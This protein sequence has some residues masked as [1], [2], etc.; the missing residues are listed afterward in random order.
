MIMQSYLLLVGRKEGREDGREE[1]K[2]LV[3][4]DIN[5]HNTEYTS[6]KILSGDSH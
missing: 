1:G 3:L 6:G 5:K 4:F 2:E